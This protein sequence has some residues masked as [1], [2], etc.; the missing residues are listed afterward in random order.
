MHSLHN[1]MLINFLTKDQQ[2]NNENL[3]KQICIRLF[4]LWSLSLKFK[5]ITIDSLCVH[6]TS[7]SLDKIKIGLL[8]I[9]KLMDHLVEQHTQ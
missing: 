4:V 3:N 5:Y 6:S 9:E 7:I 2:G 8:A 1:L